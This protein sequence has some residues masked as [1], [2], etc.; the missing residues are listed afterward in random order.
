LSAS[1]AVPYL[2]AV[3]P[4]LTRTGF[5]DFDLLAHPNASDP[6]FRFLSVAGL[7]SLRRIC[8]TRATAKSNPIHLGTFP[9]HPFLSGLSASQYVPRRR[10]ILCWLS[11][12]SAR[13]RLD[14]ISLP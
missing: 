7:C 3:R 9:A 1:R 10:A 14:P 12:L 6:I 4:L 5:I 2:P 11:R 8:A 13:W